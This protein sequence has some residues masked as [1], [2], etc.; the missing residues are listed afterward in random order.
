MGIQGL[1]S[2]KRKLAKLLVDAKK[3]SKAD[4]V[5]GHTQAYA[6]YVH[7]VPASHVVGEV[8]Y[9]LKGYRAAESRV[10]QN[11]PKAMQNGATLEKA[12]LIGGLLIQRESQSRTPVD[13]GALKASAFTDTYANV[14]AATVAAFDRSEAIRRTGKKAPERAEA[15]RRAKS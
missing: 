8:E 6:L 5:V 12:L 15:E 4:V 3:A 9:L 2:L 11:I 13:T 14:E 10:R 7:E 1:N